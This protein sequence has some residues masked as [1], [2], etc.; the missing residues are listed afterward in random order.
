MYSAGY[1]NKKR[2]FNNNRNLF[3]GQHLSLESDKTEYSGFAMILFNK[4]M[5]EL[6]HCPVTATGSYAIPDTVVSIGI[7]AFSQC[8]DLTSVVF[9]C[10]LKTIGCLAFDNCVSLSSIIIPDSIIWMGYRMFSNC[11]GLKSIYMQS[12]SPLDIRLDADVFYNV[13]KE[14]CML[15][16]PYGT[17]GDYQRTEQLKEFKNIQETEYYLPLFGLN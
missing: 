15:Y 3:G 9:P 6:I 11:T 12:N 4:Q 2:Y 16:V 10:N 17:K 14:N 8:K 7:E 5:S 1:P 13:D